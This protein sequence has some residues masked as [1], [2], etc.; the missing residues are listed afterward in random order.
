MAKMIGFGAIERIISS[1]KRAL[2]REAEHHIRAVEGI[3]QRAGV[4]LGRMGRFP[5]VHALGAALV[6]RRPWCRRA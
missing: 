2:R 4:G 6:D 5:L 1:V 3:R